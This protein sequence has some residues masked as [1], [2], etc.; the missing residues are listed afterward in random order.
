MG[1]A[2]SGILGT[3][4]GQGM[5][6]LDALAL[7]VFLHGMAADRLARHLGSVG[8]LAG[9]LISEVPAALAALGL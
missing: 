7:G 6:A 1:D 2:L 9:D 5:D 4:L 3:L 8:F